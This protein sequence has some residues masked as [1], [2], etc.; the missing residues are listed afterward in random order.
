MSLNSS[1]SYVLETLCAHPPSLMFSSTPHQTF[2]KAYRSSQASKRHCY[3]FLVVLTVLLPLP[4]RLYAWVA[5]LTL[6]LRFIS[7]VFRHLIYVKP[8]EKHKPLPW[9]IGGWGGLNHPQGCHS[10]SSVWKK[11]LP[12]LSM[13]WRLLNKAHKVTCNAP[14]VNSHTLV[15]LPFP[16]GQ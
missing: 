13:T 9:A 12:R 4:S 8:M 7:S 5:H 3:V 16:K 10:S 1:Y 6:W 15:W 14:N 11:M 2:Q